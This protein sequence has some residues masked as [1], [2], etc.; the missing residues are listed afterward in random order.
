[1]SVLLWGLS[2]FTVGQ[3][4]QNE[5]K[6]RSVKVQ[7]HNLSYHFTDKVIVRI[8]DLQGEMS[9]TREGS[10]VVFDDKLSFQMTVDAA[11][12]ALS[13]QDLSHALQQH[14]F[15]APDAPL[16]DLVVTA[17]KDRLKIQGKLHSKGDVPFQ[18]EGT[19]S[20]TPQGEIRVH[21]EKIKAAHVPVKGLMD[22]L[23]MKISDL[24]N[25]RKVRGVRVEGDSRRSAA[26]AHS[27]Q[28]QWRAG[29]R[30]PDPPDIR[31]WFGKGCSYTARQLYGF[32]LFAI[33]LWQTH[34]GRYRYGA[35]RY[36]SA[37]SFRFLSRSLQAA[38]AGGIHKDHAA[39]GSTRVYEGL[40]QTEVN[41]AGADPPSNAKA[42]MTP[43]R[44]SFN[45]KSWA[46]SYSLSGL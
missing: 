4:A 45:L 21:T 11:Q 41:W 27:R 3:T 5:H 38:T 36:G 10:V 31:R 24:L 25:T 2:Q 6:N 17:A 12:I 40:Q 20:T 14:A 43:T 26:T 33:S 16:K 28:D 8:F 15:S 39:V 18:T 42:A 35:D 7:M 13:L 46:K 37:G 19:L 23:G 30:E 22:L 32:P 1:M 9:P 34:H 44:S 29:G